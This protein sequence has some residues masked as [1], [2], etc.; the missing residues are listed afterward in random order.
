VKAFVEP[1]LVCST[2]PVFTTA[3]LR[4]NPHAAKEAHNLVLIVHATGVDS[5]PVVDPILI[6]LL[7][8]MTPGFGGDPADSVY[9]Q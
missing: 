4:T 9:L 3:T 7:S 5:W 1:G 2:G 6:Q 8:H